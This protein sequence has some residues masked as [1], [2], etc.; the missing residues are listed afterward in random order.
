MDK[1]DHKDSVSTVS[2]NVCAVLVLPC[3]P[4]ELSANDWYWK[5][6][7]GV[8]LLVRNIINLQR[9]GLDSLLI[10]DNVDGAELY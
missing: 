3:S 7:C 10:Y 8:P 1:I 9:A 2:R 4:S 5:K 6:I